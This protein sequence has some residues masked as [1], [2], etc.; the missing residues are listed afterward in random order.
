MFHSHRATLPRA[1]GLG[2]ML[3]VALSIAPFVVGGAAASSTWD[4][5]CSVNLR[6]R[7]STGAVIRRIVAANTSITVSAKVS[8]GAWS[9]A[10]GRSLSGSTWFAIVAIGGRSVSS[11]LGVSVVY[12]ASGLFRA[13]GP[14]YGVDVSAWQG[15]IN[16]ALVRASGRSFVIAK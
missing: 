6:S 8:G 16:F 2:L 11:L 7:P 10:C 4:T 3:A 1:L 14:S 15:A 5:N 12:A 9:A 13:P